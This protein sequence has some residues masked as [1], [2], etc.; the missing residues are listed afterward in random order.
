MDGNQPSGT[1]SR[2]VIEAAAKPMTAD[3]VVIEWDGISVAG[4]ITVTVAIRVIGPVG[5]AAKKGGHDR[6]A[7]CDC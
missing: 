5:A 4:R 2:I 7:E 3:I 1:E 6:G